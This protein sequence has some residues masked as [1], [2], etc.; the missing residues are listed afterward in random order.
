MKLLSLTFSSGL[1]MKTIS[2]FFRFGGKRG[3]F[4]SLEQN[5]LQ[6]EELSPNSEK[7]GREKKKRVS[8]LFSQKKLVPA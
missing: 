6:E 4:Q 2:S 5:A 3:N 1:F 7:R 8:S